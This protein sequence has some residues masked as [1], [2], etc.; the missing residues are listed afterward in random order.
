MPPSYKQEVSEKSALAA[1]SQQTTLEDPTSTRLGWTTFAAVLTASHSWSPGLLTGND[2]PFSS[3]QV[4]KKV[5]GSAMQRDS[6][7]TSVPSRS[8]I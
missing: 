2:E 1:N 4:P 5:H 3:T 8:Y 7:P 6:E